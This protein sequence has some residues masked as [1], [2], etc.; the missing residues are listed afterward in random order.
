M[1]PSLF[2]FESLYRELAE[3]GASAWADSLRNQ[4]DAALQ[5]DA[6]GLMTEWTSAWE[7]LPSAAGFELTTAGGVALETASAPVGNTLEKILRTFHPWR[8]GPFRIGDIDIDT[9]WRSDWKWDRVRPHVELR[10]RLVLDVG[11][12]NGYFGW[13]MLTAGASVVLGLDPFLLYVMQHEVIKRLA[14]LHPNYVLPLTDECLTEAPA[15]FDVVFD[16]G[17][18]Y[19]RAG[20]VDHLRLLAS[21]LRPGGQLVL[22]TLVIEGDVNTVLVPVSRYAKMRNVWFLPSVELLQRWMKRTGFRDIEVRDV[23][24]TSVEEQRSTDWMTFESLP[25]FLSADRQT[26]IEGYPPPTRALLTA[27]KS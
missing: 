11:C 22:E 20:P 2:E 8:K 3:R 10:D 14:G 26:T 15:V 5:P 18:L 19:H 13:H 24:P 12:G 23:T 25:D 7:Q 1:N 9:E 16:M 4:V 27:T 6:H 21:A 17:V